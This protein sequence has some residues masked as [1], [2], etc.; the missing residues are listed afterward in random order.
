MTCFIKV[1]DLEY[2]RPFKRENF[3]NTRALPI[4]D[5]GDDVK[6]YAG[7]GSGNLII[8]KEIC[9]FNRHL[10]NRFVGKGKKIV[11]VAESDNMLIKALAIGWRYR[12]MEEGGLS[13]RGIAKAE[14]K[15]GRTVYR[16]LRL[17]CLSP[18][19]VNDIMD[20]RVPKHINLQALFDIASRLPDFREQEKAFYLL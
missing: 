13:P 1:D 14:K 5:L 3:I 8:E 12:K 10:S 16:Y 6:V 9:I 2:L 15:T 17:N 7:K 4:A 18:N 19:I 20:G 11:T